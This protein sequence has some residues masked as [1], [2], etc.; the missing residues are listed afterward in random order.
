MVATPKE[1]QKLIQK[2]HRRVTE[3]GPELQQRLEALKLTIL[4]EG[5]MRGYLILNFKFLKWINDM[6][7]EQ[8]FERC[9]DRVTRRH[10]M[11]VS[12]ILKD[13]KKYSYMMRKEDGWNRVAKDIVDADSIH[14]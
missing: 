3:V 14:I 9:R 10:N 2:A 12:E 4:E 13:V 11:I 6:G 1:A 5:R 8:F 7:S